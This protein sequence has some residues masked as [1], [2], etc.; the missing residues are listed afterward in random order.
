MSWS[1][2]REGAETHEANLMNLAG[3]AVLAAM[4][5]LTLTDPTSDALGDGTLTPPTSP[6]YAHSAIF[7]IH[8]VVVGLLPQ[9]ADLRAGE[10]GAMPEIEP[11]SGL[12]TLTVTMGAVDPDVGSAAGFSGVVVDVYFDAAPGGSE[13]TL[14]GPG[15]LLP[16]GGGWEFAVRLSPAGAFGISYQE[17]ADAEASGD[18]GDHARAVPLPP[19]LTL[20]AP[21]D[22]SVAGEA[23]EATEGGASG[24]PSTGLDAEA[25]GLS[26]VPLDLMI[27]GNRLVVQLPWALTEETVV[28]ALSGV[29]DPF[30]SDSWRS[31]AQTTSPWAYSGG[32]QVAPVV[33][34]LAVDQAAQVQALTTGVLPRPQRTADRGLVWLFLMGTGVVVALVGLWLRR[35]VR[36]EVR[37]GLPYG[38]PPEVVEVDEEAVVEEDVAE[39]VG[40]DVDEGVEEDVAEGV[41]EAVAEDADEA[42]EEDVA[43]DADE[44]IDESLDNDADVA[45]DADAA[46]AIEI[47]DGDQAAEPGEGAVIVS[48]LQREPEPEPESEPEPE[49]VAGTRAEPEP[50]PE[51]ASSLES[52]PA[53]SPESEPDRSPEAAQEELVDTAD[54]FD[55]FR[56]IDDESEEDDL[57]HDR[58]EGEQI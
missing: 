30:S 12:T 34:V 1:R 8:E 29:Y 36:P 53:S 19:Q 40:V 49:P 3:L 18:Q 4:A 42:V 57:A 7:D 54:P 13:I 17:P 43:E 33:D 27:D 46:E 58:F 47:D 39:D 22:E 24:Q 10:P 28:F 20:A 5:A 6:V 52:E 55:R 41:D 35:Q 38:L 15:M 37:T 14:V 31:L 26:I 21:A 45:H 2:E 23:S 11:G 25:G 56:N 32:E 9:A 50:L 51:P 48:Q 44:S 16:A